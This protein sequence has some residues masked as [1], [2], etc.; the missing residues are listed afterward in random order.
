[1]RLTLFL[2]FGLIAGAAAA[3]PGDRQA[4]ACALNE[5]CGTVDCGGQEAIL[6]VDLAP[7]EEADGWVLRS[8]GDIAGKF[9]EIETPA[10]TAKHL[11]S[12]DIDPEAEAAALLSIFPDGE[13]VLT[14]HGAF[15]SLGTSSW[16]GQCELDLSGLVLTR[17]E[18]AG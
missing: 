10:G 4:I 18:M 8:N 15:P 1:M 6:S 11:V 7:A 12:T 9:R 14:V 17:K 13:A 3:A 5:G 2:A 16:V